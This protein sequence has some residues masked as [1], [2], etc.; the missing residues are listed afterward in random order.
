MVS[1]LW[2]YSPAHIL[3][4]RTRQPGGGRYRA[5]LVSITATTVQMSLPMRETI[6]SPSQGHT[7][8]MSQVFCELTKYGLSVWIPKGDFVQTTSYVIWTQLPFYQ[9]GFDAATQFR[10]RITSY[11]VNGHPVDKIEVLV[12]GGTWSEYP[13][14]YQKEFV[15]YE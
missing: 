7:F 5:S 2:Q 12:L 13:H 3:N 10:E 14:A 11:V 6:L 4:M 1:W 9:C 8:M 15:R